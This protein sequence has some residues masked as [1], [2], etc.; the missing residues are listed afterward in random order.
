MVVAKTGTNLA[1]PQIVQ[2]AEYLAK[3]GFFPGK[4]TGAQAV[5]VV[6]AGQELGIPPFAAMKGFYL[7]NGQPAPSSTMMAAII[8]GSD[9]YD[10]DIIESSPKRAAVTFYEK[11]KKPK[12]VEY[13]ADEAKTAG[14]YTGRNKDTWAKYPS[15]MLMSKLFGRL[16]RWYAPDLLKSPHYNPE[17]LD[18]AVDDSGTPVEVE[19]IERSDKITEGQRNDLLAKIVEVGADAETLKKHYK[20]ESLDDLTPRQFEKIIGILGAKKPVKEKARG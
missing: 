8:K 11:R 2:V 6:Q 17:E 14:H 4:V 1:L 9:K 12:T 19:V 13:T 7:I 15:E 5:A 10:Y 16:L 3:S 18:E 20:V